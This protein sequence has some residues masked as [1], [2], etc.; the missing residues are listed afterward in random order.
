MKTGRIQSVDITTLTSHGPHCKIG[1][2]LAIRTDSGA[3][4]C[5]VISL[6]QDLVRSVLLEDPAGV[7]IGDVVEPL[8]PLAVPV[9]EQV[10]GRIFSPFGEPLDGQKPP[11]G[12]NAVVGP[13]STGPPL[14]QRTVQRQLE[15]G[16]R[17]LDALLPLVQGHQY[18]LFAPN[19][20]G[21][22]TTLGMLAR[23]SKV[24]SAVCI[25]TGTQCS[26][27]TQFFRKDLVGGTAERSVL[28]LSTHHAPSSQGALAIKTGLT[29]ARALCNQGKSVLLLV[30]LAARWHPEEAE[31]N[32]VLELAVHTM[33]SSAGHR[34]TGLYRVNLAPA[35]Q[36]AL[37]LQRQFDGRLVLSREVAEKMIYPAFDLR[38]SQTDLQLSS[39]SLELTVSSVK[40]RVSQFVEKGDASSPVTALQTPG[41]QDLWNFVR[42]GIYEKAE[43]EET[44]RRLTRFS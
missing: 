41:F 30:D 31:L 20:V 23:N 32:R 36:E 11:T 19:G 24:D 12:E 14:E 44:L 40:R 1:D 10:L 3:V 18:A 5:R 27:A 13:L 42:Q 6:E 7:G 17:V 35:A 4:R 15:T 2:L 9:G 34:L 38:A 43:L 22:Y 33:R 26:D 37:R 16:V 29:M 39:E 8:G 28:V 21:L 25:F